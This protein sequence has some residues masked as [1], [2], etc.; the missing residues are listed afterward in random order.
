MCLFGKEGMFVSVWKE[1]LLK[2]SLY[3]FRFTSGPK[4]SVRS[5]SDD[6]SLDSPSSAS[7]GQPTSPHWAPLDSG[8]C[9]SQRQQS[10]ALQV[11]VICR[12]LCCL[13]LAL[14]LATDFR[15]LVW[16]QV[17]HSENLIT[18]CY[19]HMSHCMYMTKNLCRGVLMRHMA[20]CLNATTIAD[21]VP[22]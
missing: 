14:Q 2:S 9:S 12:S 8:A 15:C 19:A 16:Q 10:C 20:P 17:E 18:Y 4:S 6:G 21:S 7:G 3:L 13:I 22:N 5:P 11:M 1:G